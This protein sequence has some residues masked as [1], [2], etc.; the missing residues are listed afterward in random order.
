[1]VK[2]KISKLQVDFLHNEFDRLQRLYGD[3]SL[4]A[5]YGAGQI[6]SPKLVAVFM[7]PT[8]KNCAATG[9]WQGIHA[10]WVGTT[11]VWGLMEKLSIVS[12]EQYAQIRSLK[13]KW[14][15]DFAAEV[16]S[17]IANKGVYITNLAKCTQLDARPLPNT[18]FR[19]YLELFWQEMAAINASTLVTFGNQVSSLVCGENIVMHYDHG[20]ERVVNGYSVVPT[21]YPVGQGQRNAPIMVKD[22]SELI[23]I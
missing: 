21:Y 7:N 16:Y 1:V 13:G 10:P 12:E 22:V 5:I 17:T 19:Q 4:R 14:S 8:A 3:S 2:Q 9:D 23:S 6:N 18:V 15:E 11:L 20:I